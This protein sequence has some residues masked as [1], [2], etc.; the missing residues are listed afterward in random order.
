MKKLSV[1]FA[2][3][4]IVLTSCSK[5]DLIEA[6]AEATVTN[7]EFKVSFTVAES[8]SVNVYSIRQAESANGEYKEVAQA[9]PDNTKPE[10]SFTVPVKYTGKASVLYFKVVAVNQDNVSTFSTEVIAI[11]L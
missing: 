4:V 3:I 8:Q 10:N 11:K 2:L 7:A 6:P 9:W 5:R 1:L